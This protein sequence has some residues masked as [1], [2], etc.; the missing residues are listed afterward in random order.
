MLTGLS[1]LVNRYHLTFHTDLDDE[2]ERMVAPTCRV[3]MP[4]KPVHSQ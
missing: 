2:T 3:P 4:A 1:N